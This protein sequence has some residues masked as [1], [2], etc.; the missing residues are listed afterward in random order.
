MYQLRFVF[1]SRLRIQ[2]N[3]RILV[4]GF[5]ICFPGCT[6]KLIVPQGH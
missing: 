3:T 4:V 2:L 1:D 5:E 6:K